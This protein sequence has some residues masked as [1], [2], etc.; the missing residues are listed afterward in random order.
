MVRERSAKDRA[1]R[2]SG[3][4]EFGERLRVGRREAASR[5]PRSPA[6]MR[7][8]RSGSFTTRRIDGNPRV[9]EPR[10]YAVG[11]HHRSSR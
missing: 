8:H 9:Q 2:L 4:P 3:G 7:S 5:Q 6:T 10:G 11:G 1:P